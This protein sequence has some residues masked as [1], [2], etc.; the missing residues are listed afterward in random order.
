MVRL[1]ASG[2]GFVVDYLGIGVAVL[3]G[4]GALALVVRV[5]R[6][7][8]AAGVFL[9]V[10]LWLLACS[11]AATHWDMDM[12]AVLAVGLGGPALVLAAL[13]MAVR[14]AERGRRGR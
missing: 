14:L 10:M 2:A 5:G 8:P 1:C 12:R 4:A 11:V 3:V 7:H 9:A 13:A 6:A